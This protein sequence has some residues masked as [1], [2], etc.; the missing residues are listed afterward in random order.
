MNLG[1]LSKDLAKLAKSLLSPTFPLGFGSP[2]RWEIPGLPFQR[3]Q[4][5]AFQMGEDEY[6][7]TAIFGDMVEATY[8]EELIANR[9]NFDSSENTKNR[10]WFSI[11]CVLGVAPGLPP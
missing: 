1:G 8:L 10:L 6:L 2:S 11:L 3:A 4:F 5:L 7:S 9:S